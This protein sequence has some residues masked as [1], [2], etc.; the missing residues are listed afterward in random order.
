MANYVTDH[1]GYV[2]ISNTNLRIA[3]IGSA[4]TTPQYTAAT[5]ENAVSKVEE[6]I[7]QHSDIHPCGTTLV[8]GGSSW[9]D[10]I[11]VSL[12]LRN[13]VGGL[14]LYL[15]CEWDHLKSQ[16]VDKGHSL[17][18]KSNPG[19]TLNSYHS[20]FSKRACISSLKEIDEA[21][22]HP[23]FSYEVYPGFFARNDRVAKDCDIMIALT[24]GENGPNDGGTKYTWGKCTHNDVV[25]V[26][27]S[28][29]SL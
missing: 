3:I 7:S 15:P 2:L 17:D 12:F 25:K 9:M 5:F 29:D 19:H 22:C 6:L 28:I 11:A 23:S 10:H 14:K 8:S 13:K 1:E 16:Y 20:S 26:W 4:K 24:Q 18:W 21:M 27:Y